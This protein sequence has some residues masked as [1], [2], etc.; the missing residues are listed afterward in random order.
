LRGWALQR[1][2]ATTFLRE[3]Y[4]CCPEAMLIS[5]VFLK[6]RDGGSNS[7]SQV[8]EL[9]IRNSF[10]KSSLKRIKSLA[11]KRQLRMRES[12]GYVVIFAPDREELEIP[13]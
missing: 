1:R 11:E 7:L 8:Y 9:H 2:E 6:P 5:C 10:T 4:D 12:E 3:I 13:V